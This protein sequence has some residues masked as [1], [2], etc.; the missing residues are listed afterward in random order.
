[1]TYDDIKEI[2]YKETS[3]I[4]TPKYKNIVILGCGKFSKFLD[5]KEFKNQVVE[6]EDKH[7]MKIY[8]S[9]YTSRINIYP[10]WVEPGKLNI[11]DYTKIISKNILESSKLITPNTLTI[12]LDKSGKKG[13]TT[14]FLERIIVNIKNDTDIIYFSTYRISKNNFI[15]PNIDIFNIR[16]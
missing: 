14:H 3:K 4:Y 1:M 10:F 13:N 5:Y 7:K 2:M 9:E 6:K 8:S 16:N 15:T 12:M 11:L